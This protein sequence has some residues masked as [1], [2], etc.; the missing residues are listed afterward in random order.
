[1]R[2]AKT[3]V[4]VSLGERSYDV[5]IGPGLIAR[6]GDLIATRF[7]SARCAV[8]TD[9]NLTARHL[10]ALVAG[11]THRHAES[12]VLKPGEASKSFT[13]LGALCERLLTLGLERGDLVIAFGGGVIGDLAGLAASIVKRGVRL[14]QI[15]STLLA[16]VD[17]SIG[18][19]TAINTP[20]GKNLVGTFHQPSLVIADTELLATLPAREMRAGY[21][22]VVKYGLLGDADFFAWLE[23]NFDS[24]L[25]HDSAALAHA[26]ATSV[27]AKAAIVACDEL[28]NND[29]MRLNLGHT[30]G[31][32]LE[33]W[34]GFSARLLHGEAVAIGMAQAFRFSV[35]LAHTCKAAADRV[36]AHLSQAG[37]PTRIADIAG[38]DR[39]DVAILMR[40]MR[41][42]KKV[43]SGK[44]TLILARGIGDAF[45][46]R[47]VAGEQLADFLAREIA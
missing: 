8:V 28:E 18:G 20:Q 1:M 32:A 5:V 40:L 6:S 26:I 41:Q 46:A 34:A 30:F 47:D 45:I 3:T 2:D 23:A 12:I 31:H 16:Q 7:P 38:N 43:S 37:L 17:A 27:R 9:T 25:G 44:F 10:P 33:A 36:A 39:P 19:K 13:E 14:V 22:E 11:L 24:V 21:A 4:R 35:E 29:R 15:P 42:D